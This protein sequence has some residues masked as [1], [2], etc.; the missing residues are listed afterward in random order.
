MIAP[1]RIITDDHD[2]LPAVREVFSRNPEMRS[3]EAWEM[4]SALFVLGYTDGLAS[5]AQIAAAIEVARTDS[6][7]DKD[8]A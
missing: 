7:P 1:Q 8:V 4:Q 3:L 5:E 6:G 2:L